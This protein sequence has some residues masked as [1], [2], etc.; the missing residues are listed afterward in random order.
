[1]SAVRFRPQPHLVSLYDTIPETKL[2]R[3]EINCRLWRKT[4]SKLHDNAT[5]VWWHCEFGSSKMR[6][7]VYTNVPANEI[8]GTLALIAKALGA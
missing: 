3:Y 7:S 1:V 6:R 2:A 4:G 5:F 8:A